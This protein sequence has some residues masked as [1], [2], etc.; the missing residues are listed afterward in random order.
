MP[1]VVYTQKKGLVQATGDD[2]VV[3]DATV[4]LRAGVA[5]AS[6][7]SLTQAFQAAAAPGTTNQTI[8]ITQ[9]KTGI[10]YD[11]PEGAG[12]WTL[13]TAALIVAGLPDYVV[14]DCLDFSVI[15]NAT[16]GADEIITMERWE[17]VAQ[18]LETC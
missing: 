9:L 10:L 3:N 17:P 4:R 18:L 1:K 15:N 13:P 8:T 2:F 11:D 7:P 14:G 16:T 12:T 6:A 5:A